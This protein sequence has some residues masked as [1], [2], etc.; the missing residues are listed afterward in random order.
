MTFFTVNSER[1]L[2]GNANIQ[3][4]IERLTG[5]VNTLQSQLSSLSDSWQGQAAQSF[6]ELI[7]RWRTTSDQVDEQL[8]QIGNALAHAAQQYSDI[9]AANQR[10]FL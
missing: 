6:Q 3:L 7:Q 10:L 5:E 2:A 8:R 1:I 9:E 4:T